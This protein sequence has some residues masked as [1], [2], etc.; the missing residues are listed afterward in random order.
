M[1]LNPESSSELDISSPTRYRT[2]WISDVHL[3]L[4]ESKAEFLMDFLEKTDAHT[5]YLVGDI[6]DGWALK[7]S[8][9]W[10]STH[11]NVVQC[12][13]DIA[14]TSDVVY[15]PGNH[16]EAARAF[17]GIR[18]GGIHLKKEATHTTADGRRFLLLHGD[19]FDGV[20]RHARW[21]SRLGAVAYT[22]ILKLNRYVNRGRRWL[23]MPYWS[24]SSYLKRRTKKAVQF[25]ADFEDA[26]ARRARLENVDGVV[27][28][29]I[30]HPEMRTIHGVQY[31]NT[32][33]WVE[34]CTALVEHM[35]G[36]MELLRW[37]PDGRGITEPIAAAPACS[38]QSAT[39][40]YEGRGDGREAPSNPVVTPSATSGDGQACRVPSP[41]GQEAVET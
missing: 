30:H 12:L 41:P 16:D 3:G 24:L 22:G 10:P 20:I 9:Y 29:H 27:C 25:I 1:D 21:L 14:S 40:G 33:D 8:W 15:I 37:L 35:D 38:I 6:I 11:N 13:L 32:G 17:P 18:L 28:G 34:S 26:V 2:I 7:R 4:R 36:R 23:G 5:Y 19:E 31:I 39:D